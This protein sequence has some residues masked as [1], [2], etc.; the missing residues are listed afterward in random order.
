[1]IK[2]GLIR[3]YLR[4]FIRSNFRPIPVG[5]AK[6]GELTSS[7]VY[8]TIAW[9]VF[10]MTLYYFKKTYKPNSSES[11]G[12]IAFTPYET[13]KKFG[14]ENENTLVRIKGFTVQKEVL[15]LDEVEQK[16]EKRN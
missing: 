8:F 16:L 14:S 9:T 10:G 6:R 3:H 11:H 2:M 4:V 12:F 5:T 7:L 1:D 15:T 13:M